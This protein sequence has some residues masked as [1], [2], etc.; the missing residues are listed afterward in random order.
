MGVFEWDGGA[1]GGQHPKIWGFRGEI[2]LIGGEGG[3]CRGS[4]PKFGG[5]GGY[6]PIMGGVWGSRGFL[7]GPGEGT[8]KMNGG[9]QGGGTP[10]WRGDL[11]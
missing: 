6:T 7:G 8:C 1:E 4:T 5:L 3:I 9:S 2:P 11:F 10:K